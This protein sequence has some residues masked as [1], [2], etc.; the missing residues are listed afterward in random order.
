MPKVSVI[1]PARNEPYLARTVVDLF[2][3]ARGEIQVIVCLEG[4]WPDNWADT[5]DKYPGRI[6]TIH[7]GQPHG[8]RASINQAAAIADGEFLM[9]TD[10][11]CAFSK[12]FDVQL[13]ADFDDKTVTIPRRYRLDPEKWARIKDGRP[14]VDYE[15]LSVPDGKGGGLKGKIWEQRAKDRADLLLDETWLFQGSCWFMRKGYFYELDLM[16]E[17]NYG[18]FWKEALEIGNKAWLSG[19]KV[20]VNKRVWYAHWHKPKRGY[21]M[22][23]E[24]EK[25]AQAFS[26][27]WVTDS[28]GWN[29]QT[30]LFQSLL[31]RFSPPG[32]REWKETHGLQEIPTARSLPLETVRRRNEVQTPR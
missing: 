29:K 5:A 13:V 6:I 28:T 25:K 7:H 9:K 23:S 12:G 31:D 2:E 11:H 26:E 20:L 15:Y 16:D 24:D 19:G 22:Q 17:G 3:K 21:S 30:L 18:S 4:Y 14:P 32:W 10:A 27:R 1:I 8:M